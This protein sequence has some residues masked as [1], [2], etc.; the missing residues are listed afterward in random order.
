[1]RDF[2]Y[3]QLGGPNWSRKWCLLWGVFVSGL[4]RILRVAFFSIHEFAWR[5]FEHPPPS[6]L[7]GLSRPR[8]MGGAHQALSTA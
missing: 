5:I 4:Y 1:M 8:T 7:P 6:L 3:R 2:Y